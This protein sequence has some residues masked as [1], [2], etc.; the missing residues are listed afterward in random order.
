MNMK[1]HRMT[2]LSLIAGL[3]LASPGAIAQINNAPMGTMAKADQNFL[4][5]AVQGDLSEIKMGKLAQQKGQSEGVKQFGQ[6]LEQD[7]SQHLQKAKQTAEQLG[8]TTPTEPNKKQTAMYDH[9]SQL[10]GP[11]FD[12]Q[13]AQ[14]MVADHKEDIGKFQKEAKS[15]G[16]LGDFAQQTIPTLQ[17]HLRTAESLTKQTSRR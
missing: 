15:K 8:L 14:D 13:F 7:H 16:P 2:A 4:N 10:S 9:L 1:I 12:R 11:Q 3:A 5:E 17:K 6:M